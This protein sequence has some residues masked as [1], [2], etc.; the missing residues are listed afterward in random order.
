MPDH[1]ATTAMARRENPR[2]GA[3]RALRALSTIAAASAGDGAASTL[4]APA[5]APGASGHARDCHCGPRCRANACCCDPRIPN[6]IRA[7]AA[8]APM[9]GAGRSSPCLASA[10]CQDPAT[11]PSTRLASELGEHACH[12]QWA[13]RRDRRRGSADRPDRDRPDRRD[14]PAAP[15]APARAHRPAVARLGPLD[16]QVDDALVLQLQKI[17]SLSKNPGNSALK[18]YM[19]TTGRS[20]SAALLY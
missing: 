18:G 19:E 11:P 17:S 5:S 1:E 6:R 7:G 10:P 12:H 4:D 13:R 3:S 15:P 16:R 8:E 14:G 20:I 2:V 9:P